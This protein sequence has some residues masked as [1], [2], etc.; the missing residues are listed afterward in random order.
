[1]SELPV[2][3]ILGGANLALEE[4]SLQPVSR[5]TFDYW[6][7][8]GIIEHPKRKGKAGRGFLP[9]SA[10]TK[11]VNL[12]ELQERYNFTLSDIQATQKNGSD[13]ADVLGFMTSVEASYG[14]ALIPFARSYSCANHLTS[15][16]EEV[17]EAF[18]AHRIAA[19][20]EECGVEE[21]AEILG[22]DAGSIADLVRVRELPAHGIREPRF[23]KSEILQWKARHS[24]ASAPMTTVINQ[25]MSFH[26]ELH[27]IERVDEA[28]DK[29]RGWLLY[30]INELDGEL[31]R[32]RRLCH[33]KEMKQKMLS[34][35][36]PAQP[37]QNRPRL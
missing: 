23:L 13:L 24:T 21:V 4:R 9:D 27:A 30:W 18:F 17:H 16:P 6:M 29:Q 7:S 15:D 14:H 1:M 8:I 31:W 32:I 12:R 11:I 33:E 36:R 5:R 34:P 22:V 10:L 35:S 2:S 19:G 28:T 25:M 20:D 26:N 3:E 37:P